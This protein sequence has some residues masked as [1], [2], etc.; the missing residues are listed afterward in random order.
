[1]CLIREARTPNTEV[2]DRQTD[3]APG[4]THGAGLCQDCPREKGRHGSIRSQAMTSP[5]PRWTPHC[6]RT[7]RAGP[8]TP[9]TPHRCPDCRFPKEPRAGLAAPPAASRSRSARRPP[10]THVRRRHER[11]RETSQLL[12]VI[13]TETDTRT[14]KRKAQLDRRR[15]RDEPR[16]QSRARRSGN[17]WGAGWDPAEV[18]ERPPV[19]SESCTTPGI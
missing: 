11:R 13:V 12:N 10:V 16:P 9:A 14:D 3:L 1:M 19:F 17:S 15:P 8:I 18:G 4:K 2:T 5:S 6:S 7:P